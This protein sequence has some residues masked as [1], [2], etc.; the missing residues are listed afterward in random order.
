[1]TAARLIPRKSAARRLGS[2]DD[3]LEYFVCLNGHLHGTC[4]LVPLSSDEDAD[5]Q[6]DNEEHSIA[7][8]DE[9]NED[10]DYDDG[11]SNHDH[12]QFSNGN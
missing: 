1:M 9:D 4:W 12:T 2:S 10:D 8:G 3:A 11:S 7:S 6:D 5:D